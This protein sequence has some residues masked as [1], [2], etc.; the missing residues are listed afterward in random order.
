MG[1]RGVVNTGRDEDIPCGP[2]AGVN[3]SMQS[4]RLPETPLLRLSKESASPES[5]GF[6]VWSYDD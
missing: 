4:H 2:L 3:R 1:R 6:S 5:L